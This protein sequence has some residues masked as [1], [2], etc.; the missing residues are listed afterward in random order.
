MDVEFDL[1]GDPIP[2]GHGR[3][4]RPQHVPTAENRSKIML[5]QAMGWPSERMANALGITPKTLRRHYSRE[6]KV[7]EQA[8]DRVDAARHMALWREV[9]A[10]NVTAMKELA[11]VFERLD[12]ARTAKDYV[13]PEAE[14]SPTGLGKKEA[15]KLAAARA[16]EGTDW[17][18]DLL[19]PRDARH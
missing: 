11:R 9:A 8:R 1:L 19:G 14:A 4:G 17:G 10:G 15:A 3:R 2:P 16:G 7:R 18:D 5:L 6:L 12:L 13:E